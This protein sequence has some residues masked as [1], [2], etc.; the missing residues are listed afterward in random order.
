MPINKYHQIRRRFTF[1]VLVVLTVLAGL[2]VWVSIRDYNQVIS[3]A[4]KRSASYTSA[5]KEHAERVFSESD[6][7]LKEL[8]ENIQGHG[9]IPYT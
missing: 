3:G 9:G 1:S 2:F 5:L 8:V 6:S 4:E 7:T